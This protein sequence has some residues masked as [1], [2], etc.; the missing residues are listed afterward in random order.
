MKRISIDNGVSFC[1]VEEAL[2]RV[3]FEVFVNA[4]DDDVRERAH[5][6]VAPCGIQKFLT[7]YLEL[8]KEDLII[9]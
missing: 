6:D 5:A 2:S 3:P 8:A 1:S 7:H 4:M 9:G